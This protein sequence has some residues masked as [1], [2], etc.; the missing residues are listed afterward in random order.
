MSDKLSN[1]FLSKENISQLYKQVIMNNEFTNL[2]KQQKD[3]IISKLIE[4][5]KR[6][7]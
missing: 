2:T 1:I 3:F 7:Y 6:I 4:N 5:M